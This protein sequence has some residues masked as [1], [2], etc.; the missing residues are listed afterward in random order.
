MR[1]IGGLVAEIYMV[2]SEF[3]SKKGSKFSKKSAPLYVLLRI[4]RYNSIQ[5]MK[6]YIRVSENMRE[7]LWS[8]WDAVYHAILT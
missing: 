5:S 4:G 6:Y 8:M 2:L 3:Q 7:E 1:I